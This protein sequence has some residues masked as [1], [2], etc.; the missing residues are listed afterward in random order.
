[1]DF[2]AMNRGRLEDDVSAIVYLTPEQCSGLPAGIAGLHEYGERLRR[3]A[4]KERS[5]AMQQGL[6]YGVL[7]QE[8]R[9]GAVTMHDNLVVD[10][11]YQVSAN[12]YTDHWCEYMEQE[13]RKMC[14]EPGSVRV[15]GAYAPQHS[16]ASLVLDCM[17]KPLHH[18]RAIGEHRMFVVRVMAKQLLLNWVLFESTQFGDIV[19]PSRHW[20][21]H[22][23]R[24]K[25]IAR[26]DQVTVH[27][28]QM[29]M[30]AETMVVTAT[31]FC[32]P[33]KVAA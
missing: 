19:V 7:S 33:A 9:G 23:L 24:A 1:M 17:W 15:V 12:A 29:R 5:D 30:F 31:A 3:L 14:F 20:V 25:G 4:P 13:P 28:G 16:A 26:K 22:D 8:Y 11:T 27:D 2:F 18:V 32:V 21:T 10:G 6:Q